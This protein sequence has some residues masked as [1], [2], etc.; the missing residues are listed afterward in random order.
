[1]NKV[2]NSKFSNTKIVLDG[3]EYTDCVFDNCVIEYS[4][5]GPVGLVGCSLN[6]CRWAFSGPAA[7]TLAFLTDMYHNMGDFGQK[8]VEATFENIKKSA[9]PGEDSR[10]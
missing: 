10:F 4:G 3:I 9:H 7:N 2:S 6:N 1:M 8:M 5:K